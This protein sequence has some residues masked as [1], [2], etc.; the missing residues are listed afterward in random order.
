MG[1]DLEEMG[2]ENAAATGSG[3]KE[4]HRGVDG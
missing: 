2:G 4:R 1:M 3:G